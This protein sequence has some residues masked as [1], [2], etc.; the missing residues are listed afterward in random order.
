ML[1]VVVDKVGV[2]NNVNFVVSLAVSAFVDD[3][4]PP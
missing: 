2:H 1:H 3:N 4:V